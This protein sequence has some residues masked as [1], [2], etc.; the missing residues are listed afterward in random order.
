MPPPNERWC[1]ASRRA[2][3]ERVD[4]LAEVRGV[5]VGG[6]EQGEDERTLLDGVA[7][8][9]DVGERDAA[10]ELHRAV[11][12][13]QLVDAVDD[14]R[15]VVVQE[16]ELVGVPQQRQRAVADQ[17]H[18]RLVAG[19]VEEAHLVE[20]LVLAEDVAL[21]LDRDQRGE[22]VVGRVRPLPRDRFAEMRVHTI[23]GG[24]QGRQLLGQHQGLEEL[25]DRVRPVAELVAVGRGHAEH[26]G[27]HREGE[28]EGE[29]A[30]QVDGLAAGGLLGERVEQLVDE[31]LDAGHERV[32]AAGCERLRDQA[33]DPGVVGRV[34]VE[35]GPA[36]APGPLHLDRL[37]QVGPAIGAGVGVHHREGRVAQHPADVVVPGQRPRPERALVDGRLLPQPGVL[38]IRVVEEAGLER[39]EV[40][41]AAGSC[42]GVGGAHSGQCREEGRPG[43]R[44]ARTHPLGGEPGRLRQSVAKKRTTSREFRDFCDFAPGRIR[45][46]L[47]AS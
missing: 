27:D 25:H 20:E 19:D 47:R 13:E 35:D 42:V 21:L 15:R 28:G 18:G 34:E 9:L 26:L 24:D 37:E 44:A 1:G 14:Q 30:D 4:R 41:P 46:T 40:E 36:P 32:D 16:L 5:V 45:R 12:A 38:G 6:A 2:E 8:E 11:V 31:V 22:Q 43:C 3:V 29:A 10:R 7:A 39:V 33:P 17:V 23:A